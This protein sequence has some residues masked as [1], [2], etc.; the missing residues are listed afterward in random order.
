MSEF[1]SQ[2]RNMGTK[3]FLGLMFQ[4]QTN[5]NLLLL[6][7]LCVSNKSQNIC[8]HL[9]CSSD[10]LPRYFGQNYNEKHLKSK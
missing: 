2:S 3:F 7:G 1:R 4:R 9:G 6:L 5:L 10:F 8:T